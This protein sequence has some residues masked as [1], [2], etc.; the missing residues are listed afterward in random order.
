M[1]QN[2]VLTDSS[3]KFDDIFFICSSQC[4]GS[5]QSDASQTISDVLPNGEGAY[6][7]SPNSLIYKCTNITVNGQ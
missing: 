4:P 2:T 1:Q 5:G 7:L 6:N 3:G